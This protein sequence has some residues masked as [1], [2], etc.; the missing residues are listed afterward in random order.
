VVA[1]SSPGDEPLLRLDVPPR[2][3]RYLLDVWSCRDLAIST[4]KADHRA[5]N[6]GFRFGRS[7]FIL[8]PI[9]RITVYGLV[10]GVL[11]AGR[12]P[13]DFLAFIA[14][15]IFTFDFVHQIIQHGAASLDNNSNLVRSLSFP[16]ALLPM[17]AALR[18]FFAFRYE[19]AV[20]F[21]VVTVSTR[22]VAVGWLGFVFVVIPMASL[23]ASS[24]AL[25]VAPA[26]LRFRDTLKIL[27]HVF[28]LTFFLSGALFPISLLADAHPLLRFLPLNP[29]YAFIGLGRHLTIAADPMADML[30]L[31]AALWTFCS[32]LIG[33]S[34][35]RRDEHR[36]ARS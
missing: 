1:R 22:S 4:A 9:L 35:F 18:Q 8:T 32:A 17:S 15:G 28:R 19:A 21:T 16:R 2:L 12:R 10:F 20:M 29:F 26:V 11:L 31:S 36:Y 34:I 33:L 23:F 27:P 25:L 30:W 3:D 24:A 6:N 13:D 5:S 14:V 7:W